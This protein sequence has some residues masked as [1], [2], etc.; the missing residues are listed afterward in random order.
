MKPH[1]VYHTRITLL[2]FYPIYVHWKHDGRYCSAYTFNSTWM[3]CTSSHSNWNII[4]IKMVC[5]EWHRLFWNRFKPTENINTLVRFM[6]MHFKKLIVMNRPAAPSWAAGKFTC[7]RIWNMYMKWTSFA[8]DIFVLLGKIYESI[9]FISTKSNDERI[10]PI[11]I[12][13]VNFTQ[14]LQRSSIRMLRPIWCI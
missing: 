8:L 10:I 11:E 9:D 3:L 6:R 13:R 5:Y 14:V 4:I 12:I 2:H 7:M 1:F